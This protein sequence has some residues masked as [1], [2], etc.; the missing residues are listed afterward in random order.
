M[1]N[2]RKTWMAIGLSAALLLGA[3]GDDDDSEGDSTTTTTEEEAAGGDVEEY[4]AAV[5]ELESTDE[6]PTVEQVEAIRDA[7][8]DEIRAEIDLV[9]DAFV[10]G[11]ES[12]DL[13]SVFGDPE[14]TQALEDVIEPFEEEN[15]PENESE[16]GEGDDLSV[17]PTADAAAV[18]VSAVDYG[19]EFETPAA[20]VSTFTM[21][22][23]GAEPHFMYI[24]QLAEGVTLEDAV[25]AE[26]EEG[27]LTGEAGSDTASPGETAELTVD[28]A[29][30]EYGMLCFIEN[31]EGVP[32]VELG[33]AVPF[34]VS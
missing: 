9:V 11:I 14:V 6:D 29:P 26:G 18:A 23:N 15:C 7:A 27:T 22:N 21:T 34:T 25:A 4:C 5:A 16:G 30:G 28:L 3:C 2:H 32:H 31:A 33:M 19:F 1:R 8:P 12:G 24:V 17:E 20:G 10:E 13:N